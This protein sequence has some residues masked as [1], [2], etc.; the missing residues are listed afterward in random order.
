MLVLETRMY[1]TS[2]LE[3]LEAEADEEGSPMLAKRAGVAK[4]E[5]TKAGVTLP[6]DGEHGYKNPILN[7]MKTILDTSLSICPAKPPSLFGTAEARRLGRRPL[8][9]LGWW[10]LHY[11]EMEVTMNRRLQATVHLYEK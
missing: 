6:K 1:G 9:R 10:A 4:M 8:P 2:T 7:R 3:E 5:N 11:E